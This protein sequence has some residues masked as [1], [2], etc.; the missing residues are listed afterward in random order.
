LEDYSCRVQLLEL[1]AISPPS[2]VPAMA[3]KSVDRG[4]IGMTLISQLQQVLA[5]RALTAALLL[6]GGVILAGCSAGTIADHMPTAAGGLPEGM[7]QRPATPAAYPAVHDLPPKRD[8]TVLTDEEQKKLEDDLIA[9]RNRTSGAAAAT[10]P[11]GS[12]R[13]P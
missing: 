7:P 2:E 10:K 9:A 4:C 5:R 1:A 3:R 11:A 8:S 6:A 13:N 12:A